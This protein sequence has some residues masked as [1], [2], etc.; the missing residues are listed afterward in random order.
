MRIEIR[1]EPEDHVR[2]ALV[3]ALEAAVAPPEYESPWRR[4]ALHEAV[5]TDDP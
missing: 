2:S 1:P 4:A 3:E 5:E